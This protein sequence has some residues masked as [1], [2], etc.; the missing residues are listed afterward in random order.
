MNKYKARVLLGMSG[1]VDSSVSAAILRDQGYEV[2]GVT[3]KQLNYGVFYGAEGVDESDSCHIIEDAEEVCKILGIEHHVVD[4]S[5]QFKET[6]VDNFIEEYL[7]GRTPNPC[8]RCNPMIKWGLFLKKADE[9][10]CKYFATG[11]YAKI[12]YSNDLN[13]YYVS[14]G[15][16]D[17]KDQSYFLWGLSQDQISRT[18][19]PLGDYTKVRTREIAAEYK[20]PVLNKPESQEIC[21]AASD[22]YHEFLRTA[23]P[24]IETK[25]NGGDILFD[26]I[27]V[28]KHKGFPFYTIGQRKGIG[29]T[30]HKPL[31][32]KSID[33]GSNTVEVAVDE[34]L[35]NKGLTAGTINYIKYE[36]IDEDKIFNVKVRY[37]DKG[38]DARCKVNNNN[39]LEIHLLTP[40]RAITPGQS[41]VIYENDDLV[42]GGIINS[43]F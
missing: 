27:A 32:V 42:A 14:K 13:R 21:F 20:L 38:T 9:L 18:L 16:D 2:I 7:E 8:S 28:G 12:N 23:V 1:G 33:A 34:E 43:W 37:K 22:N 5:K 36:N 31:Y 39:E 6:I 41:V 19:F 11:H 26:G 24:D 30:Y 4:F 40:K 15:A 10:N 25:Y 3:M 35:L 17:R 29:V